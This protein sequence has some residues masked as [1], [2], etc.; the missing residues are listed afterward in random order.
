MSK[1]IK[2]SKLGK[3]YLFLNQ[4]HIFLF[5]GVNM[6][7]FSQYAILYYGRSKIMHSCV[8]LIQRFCSN[9]FQNFFFF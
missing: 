3:I 9:F 2:I 8:D 7:Y 5:T 1:L 4:F 6:M